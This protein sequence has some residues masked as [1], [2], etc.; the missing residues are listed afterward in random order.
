M[1]LTMRRGCHKVDGSSLGTTTGSNN[2][3]AAI[4]APFRLGR[5]NEIAQIQVSEGG[6]VEGRRAGAQRPELLDAQA[7]D[8]SGDHQLLDLAGAFE[9]RVD[10]R[11]AVPAL[12]RV[13]TGVA[14]AA[15]DL[16]RVLG[17]TH[18]HFA[19]LVLAHRALA[20]LEAAVA[21]AATR[22]AR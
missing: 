12:D 11:V 20:V 3:D 1:A 18:G 7:G 21:G 10:L 14:V 19:G 17:D 13:L 9:D 16:D 8:R 6:G 2:A 5:R 22:H 15:E 4:W